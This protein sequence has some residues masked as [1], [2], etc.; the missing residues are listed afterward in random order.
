MG[1]TFYSG[2]FSDTYP[3]SVIIR[4]FEKLYWETNH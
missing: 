4:K 3:D 2:T 1:E